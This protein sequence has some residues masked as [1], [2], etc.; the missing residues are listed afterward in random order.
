MF[1]SVRTWFISSIPIARSIQKS[2][3]AFWVMVLLFCFI[4]PTCHTGR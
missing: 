2:T 4:D 1:Y 3:V